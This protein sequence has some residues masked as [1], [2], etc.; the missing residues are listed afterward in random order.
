MSVYTL[1]KAKALKIQK[2]LQLGRT[3]TPEDHTFKFLVQRL[4][5]EIDELRFELY[6]RYSARDWDRIILELADC[7][8]ILDFIHAK[9][10]KMMVE[11]K[12]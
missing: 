3:A 8:N 7:Y 4:K 12:S 9:I 5:E 11:N 2:A 10:K 6:P 1:E